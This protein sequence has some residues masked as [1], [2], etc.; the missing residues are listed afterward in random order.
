MWYTMV[1]DMA[2]RMRQPSTSDYHSPQDI[3]FGDQFMRQRMPLCRRAWPKT[4]PHLFCHMKQGFE[5]MPFWNNTSTHVQIAPDKGEKKRRNHRKRCCIILYIARFEHGSNNCGEK[6]SQCM[7]FPYVSV[8]L[9]PKH[10]TMHLVTIIFA[11][12]GNTCLCFDLWICARIVMYS[13]IY[14]HVIN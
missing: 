3:D 9:L 8:Q 2:R 10:K 11:Y 12:I 6:D 14:I 5:G 7:S 13:H 1:V 4:S